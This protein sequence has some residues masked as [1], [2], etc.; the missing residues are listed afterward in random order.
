[1]CEILG[2]YMSCCKCDKPILCEANAFTNG[3][4]QPI[5][6]QCGLSAILTDTEWKAIE[7][8]KS[9]DNIVEI[10]RHCSTLRTFPPNKPWQSMTE[11]SSPSGEVF[12]IV[13]EKTGE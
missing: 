5:C 10:R 8:V 2:R 13:R 4:G 1:M 9:G 3:F 12:C 7:R 11:F 6:E